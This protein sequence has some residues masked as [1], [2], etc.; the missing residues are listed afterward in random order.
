MERSKSRAC[1]WIST[2]LIAQPIDLRCK[3]SRQ[4]FTNH[5]Y[6]KGVL[7]RHVTRMKLCFSCWMLVCFVGDE[8]YEGKKLPML[9]KLF[10][11]GHRK[12][13]KKHSDAE[14]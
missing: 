10:S 5:V 4:L 14:T 11:F 9:S 13:G 8:V 7:E 2:T 3:F 1:H 12:A 6:A